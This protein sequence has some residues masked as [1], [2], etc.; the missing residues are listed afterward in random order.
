MARG[1]HCKQIRCIRKKWWFH[2]T[3]W[4]PSQ[5]G[6]FQKRRPGAVRWPRYGS[7]LLGGFL[8]SQDLKSRR[9]PLVSLVGE[10]RVSMARRGGS[11]RELWDVAVL[12]LLEL[13]ICAARRAYILVNKRKAEGNALPLKEAFAVNPCRDWGGSYRETLNRNRSGGYR[14]VVDVLLSGVRSFPAG[15]V[16][17]TFATSRSKE[18]EGFPPLPNGRRQEAQERH[19]PKG[20]VRCSSDEHPCH[21]FLG[22]V[23]LPRLQ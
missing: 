16:R 6:P 15:P 7:H 13:V 10:R 2:L 1:V 12:D 23:S 11:G 21:T 17:S 9:G 8:L 20:C 3:E 19:P 5:R 14:R 22:I 4:T 18:L